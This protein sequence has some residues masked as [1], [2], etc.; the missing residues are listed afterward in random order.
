VASTSSELKSSPLLL[1]M[2]DPEDDNAMILQNI[3]NYLS[4]DTV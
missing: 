4:S 3:V 1:E 2:L